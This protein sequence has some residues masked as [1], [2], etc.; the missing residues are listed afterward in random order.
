M[1]SHLFYYQLALLAILWLFVMLH[2]AGSHRGVQLPPPATPIKPKPKRSTE[3]KAFDGLTHKPPCALCERDTAYPKAP[4]PAPPDPM[5]PTNRRPRIIHTSRHFCP[6]DNC[7]YRGWLG[8]GNLQA[9]GHPNSG[10]WRQFHCTACKGYFLETRGMMQGHPLH[11]ADAEV[12]R[13]GRGPS[14]A[15]RAC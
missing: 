5:A 11:G 9:N 2:V 13:T 6:Y 4:P 1:V 14:R 7:R 8:A 10:L 3:P 12:D 15:R